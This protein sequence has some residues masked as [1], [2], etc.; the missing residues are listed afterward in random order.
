MTVKELI[1]ELQQCPIDAIVGIDNPTEDRIFLG[2]LELSTD[3]FVALLFNE[4]LGDNTHF[5][6][7]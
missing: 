7:L 6:P 4:R 1:N 3:N 5:S 2:K